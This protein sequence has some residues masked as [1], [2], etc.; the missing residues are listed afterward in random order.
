MREHPTIYGPNG[1]PLPNRKPL[2]GFLADPQPIT[3]HQ[4]TTPRE[5]EEE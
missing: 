2:I 5:G 4:P 1:E 3:E